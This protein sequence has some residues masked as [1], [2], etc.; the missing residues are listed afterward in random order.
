MI[1]GKA[2]PNKAPRHRPKGGAISDIASALRRPFNNAAHAARNI[3]G[4]AGVMTGQA[5]QGWGQMETGNDP[6]SFASMA[7]GQTPQDFIMQRFNA[8]FQ[9]PQQ[10]QMPQ[11]PYSVVSRPRSDLAGYGGGQNRVVSRP[12]S[13]GMFGL[14]RK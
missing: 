2:R 1:Y 10:P 3:G 14:N 12:R 8:M 6:N 9:R 4:G 11:Q 5:A 7:P 13:A